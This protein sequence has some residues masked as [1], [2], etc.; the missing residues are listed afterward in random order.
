MLQVFV[1]GRRLAQIWGKKKLGFMPYSYQHRYWHFIGP[2]LLVPVYFQYEQISWIIKTRHWV[3]LCWLITF[4]IK[5]GL[6]YVPLLGWWGAFW[7]Y[8]IM[9][10]VESHYFVYVTQMNHLPMHIDFDFK[11]D[12]P[13]VQNLATC[14]VEGSMFNDWFTGHLNYQVEHHLFP[15][16][17][18]HN[19]PKA[20]VLVRELFDK[21]GVKLQTKPLFT[22]LCD[23]VGCLKEYSDVWYEAYYN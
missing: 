8:M 14:N 9:R 17:P 21:H 12:W 16:M 6:I 10:V 3:D 5:F 1:V 15:S 7:L 18:R 13:T 22:A 4:Y 2:P 20:N 19:Y 23:V 11:D